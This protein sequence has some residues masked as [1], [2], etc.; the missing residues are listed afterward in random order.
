MASRSWNRVELIGNLTRDPELRY[1]PN[2][3]AVCTFGMATN[4]TY[5]TEGERKEEAD[6]HRLV[7][8]NKLAELCNQLLKKGNKVFISGRL[9][10]R[11]W[12][13]QDGQTKT[14]TEIVVEDMILLTPKGSSDYPPPGDFGPEPV[15]S[16]K[17][18]EAEEPEVVK[19][20]KASEKSEEKESS[21]EK[22]VEDKEPK[23]EKP[24]PKEEVEDD[25]PF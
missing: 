6:F 13:A 24:A 8:W 5:V 16:E 20:E 18:S 15:K 4:R 23:A 9:Q 17:V 25:L 1:T 3:A 7:A 22:A 12:E 11:S 14:I 10:T 19:E 21:G 2:G